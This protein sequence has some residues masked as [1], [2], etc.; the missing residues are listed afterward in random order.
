VLARSTVKFHVSGILAKLN[1]SS[2][3]EAV[4]LALQAGLIKPSDDR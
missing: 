4:R 2:R 1:V 3:I